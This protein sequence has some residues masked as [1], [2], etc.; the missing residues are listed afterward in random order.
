MHP[1]GMKRT[2]IAICILFLTSTARA[3]LA[4]ETDAFA[5]R[6]MS[7]MGG[8]PA[9]SVAVIKDGQ[10]ILERAWGVAD[11]EARIPASP[12]TRFY[13]ASSTKPFTAAAARLLAEEGKLDLDA[14]LKKTLPRLEFAAPLSTERVSLRD[15]LAHRAGITSGAVNFRFS[16]AGTMTDDDI[17]ASFK[18]QTDSAPV[19]FRYSN[20]AYILAGLALEEATGSQWQDVLRARIFEPLGMKSTSTSMSAGPVAASYLIDGGAPHRTPSKA[21]ATMH[22]AGGMVST[23]PD[24]ARFV[25][26]QL[27]GGT[28][29]GKRVFP[30]HA[31]RELHS[32]QVHLSAAWGP[33]KRKAYG[34]GWYLADYEGDTVVHHFGGFGGAYAHLSFMP[35]HG[36]GV[37]LLSNGGRDPAEMLAWF[38]YDTLL[39]K[40][41]RGS[42]YD[43]AIAKMTAD[44]TKS[45]ADR[46]AKRKEM[47]QRLKNPPP[48]SHPLAAYQGTY[49][50]NRLGDVIVTA[51]NGR[52]VATTGVLSPVLVPEGGD[53]FS[54]DWSG[55]V[56]FEPVKFVFD[57]K[58]DAQVFDWDG[59]RFERVP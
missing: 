22:P 23:A 57:G 51:R 28:I 13:I 9:L 21:D 29:G 53:A 15:F 11:V 7:E 46:N 6:I 27:G 5:R 40:N 50:S 10:V 26:G 55:D 47:E 17:Y 8:P 52:L 3:D 30:E 48:Q 56:S 59:R 36:L 19:G 33:L 18:L 34:L 32:P 54:V 2:L 43:A 49:R 16:T 20:V 24:L 25:A 44:L 41:D 35:E 38:I 45:R 4:A 12:Q 39:K 31:I 14:P 42:K 1:E 58:T 37:V